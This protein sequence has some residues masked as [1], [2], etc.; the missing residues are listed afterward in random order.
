MPPMAT[1]TPENGLPRTDL[2]PDNTTKVILFMIIFS[3]L[4][5]VAV[6]LRIVSKC[7]QWARLAWDDALLFAAM[8]QMLAMNVMFVDGTKFFTILFK[9]TDKL[10]LFIMVDSASTSRMLHL[11]NLPSS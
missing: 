11:N 3:F 10:Q 8:V 6:V 4:A 2:R 5:L 9:R 7:M 1:G